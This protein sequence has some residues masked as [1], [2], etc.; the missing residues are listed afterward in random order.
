MIQITLSVLDH[1]GTDDRPVLAERQATFTDFSESIEWIAKQEQSLFV[2]SLTIADRL[3]SVLVLERRYYSW[4]THALVA[5][6][7]RANE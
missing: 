7:N 4:A 6:H 1:I 5:W 2:H 3:R